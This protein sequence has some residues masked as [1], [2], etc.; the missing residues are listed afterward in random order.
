[1]DEKDALP[2]QGVFQY[3][4]YLHFEL[5]YKRL[6]GSRFQ[7]PPGDA[8]AATS[9]EALSITCEQLMLIIEGIDLGSVRRR[10]RYALPQIIT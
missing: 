5:S 6:E 2:I 10:K 7:M 8:K 4:Y 3:L 9:C 1:V